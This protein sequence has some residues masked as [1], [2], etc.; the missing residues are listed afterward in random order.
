M[1]RHFSDLKPVQKPALE[2]GLPLPAYDYCLKCSHTFNLLDARGAI[3]IT[4][5]T[6]YIG[7]VRA[8]RRA[9]PAPMQR[10]ARTG[11]SHAQQGCEVS[12]GH[13]CA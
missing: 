8:W 6:G 4:E 2:L 7:R 10:S 12:R 11:L 1:L 5:R 9:W 3:S 13:F